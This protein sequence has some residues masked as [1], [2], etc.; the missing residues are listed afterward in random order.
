LIIPKYLIAYCYDIYKKGLWKATKCLRIT[1]VLNLLVISI[2][3]GDELEKV[4]GAHVFPSSIM[5]CGTRSYAIG[6]NVLH[7]I[8]FIMAKV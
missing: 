7:K 6:A 1:G 3:Y 5:L 8:I 2:T 4:A